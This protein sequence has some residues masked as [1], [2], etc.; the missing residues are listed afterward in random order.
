MIRGCLLILLI[1]WSGT[2]CSSSRSLR[3]EEADIVVWY[4]EDC[5][6]GNQ[7]QPG[8]VQLVDG[9]A[10]MTE[11]ARFLTGSSQD[12][13]AVPPRM[14]DA[15]QRRWPA[16][17]GLFRSGLAVVVADGPHRGLVAPNKGLSSADLSVASDLVDAENSD[18]RLLDALVLSAAGLEGGRQQRYRDAVAGIRIELDTAAGA[19]VW[20]GA[21]GP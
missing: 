2:A 7:R 20:T 6:H 14:L 1:V 11:V 5:A 12:G 3:Q 17:K 4:I 15:R 19:T 21:T 8:E 18:R 10:A 9:S 16:L 13:E